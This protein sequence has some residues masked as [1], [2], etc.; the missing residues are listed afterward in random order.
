MNPKALSPKDFDLLSGISKE[1]FCR[2]RLGVGVTSA[3]CRAKP[4]GKLGVHCTTV[5]RLTK[6]VDPGWSSRSAVG[7]G[8]AEGDVD[9]AADAGSH[10]AVHSRRTGGIAGG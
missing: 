4:K 5:R 8:E 7:V 1:K 9:T 10:P 3:I 6:C 2:L